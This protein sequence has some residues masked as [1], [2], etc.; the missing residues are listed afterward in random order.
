M[1]QYVIFEFSVR[2]MA[3]YWTFWIVCKLERSGLY[4]G[5]DIKNSVIV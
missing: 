5:N 4:T 3:Q 2:A 1:S